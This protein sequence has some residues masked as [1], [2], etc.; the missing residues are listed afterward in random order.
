MSRPCWTG[1]G[2]GSRQPWQRGARG[3]RDR[4]RAHNG[5]MRLRRKRPQTEAPPPRPRPRI[6]GGPPVRTFAGGTAPAASTTPTLVPAGISMLAAA[7]FDDTPHGSFGELLPVPGNDLATRSS[8]PLEIPAPNWE[9]EAAERR[10]RGEEPSAG[11]ESSLPG[12]SAVEAML[13]LAEARGE[14]EEPRPIGS[15]LRYVPLQRPR[16]PEPD[17]REEERQRAEE[18]EA[19]PAEERTP[20]P[21]RTRGWMKAAP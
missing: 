4:S 7:G 12:V 21:D 14:L 8:A 3:P 1:A 5:S 13:A 11:D 15:P 17:W 16:I 20:N 9:L 19:L 2:P 18:G 6:H 10:E